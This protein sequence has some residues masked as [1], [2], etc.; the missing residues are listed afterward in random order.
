MVGVFGTDAL[1]CAPTCEPHFK[2]PVEAVKETVEEIK[3]NEDVK[4]DCLRV[5]WRA[6]GR[7]S[8]SRRMKSRKG[9]AGY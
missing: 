9:G 3:K 2:D 1:K 5:S 4:Y 8:R 6:R 7:M